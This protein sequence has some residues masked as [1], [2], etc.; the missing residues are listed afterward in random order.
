MKVSLIIFYLNF[1]ETCADPE[2][3]EGDPLKN[4]KNIGFLSNTGPYPLKKHKLQSQKSLLGHYRHA[5]ETPYDGPLILA[6]GSSLPL[7]LKKKRCQSGPP[8]TRLSGSAHANGDQRFFKRRS[9]NDGVGYIGEI[10]LCAV[11][12]S[13]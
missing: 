13:S 2:V 12:I 3:R 4:H 8:L 10:R 7:K 9:L 11:F 5:S 1:F 6:L